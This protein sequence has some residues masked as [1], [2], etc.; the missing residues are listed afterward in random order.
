MVQEYSMKSLNPNHL[1]VF[2]DHMCK[3]LLPMVKSDFEL[4]SEMV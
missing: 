4:V 3:G 1:E 2:T